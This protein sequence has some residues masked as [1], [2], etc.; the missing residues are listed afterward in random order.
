MTIPED[1]ERVALLGWAVF[2]ASQY[3][4]ASCF[5]GAHDAATSDL[6]TIS[7]WCRDYPSCNWRLAFGLSQLWGL[8]IDAISED[9][10]ADGIGAMRNLTAI[11]GALPPCPMTKSGGGGFAVFFKHN[12]EPITGKTGMPS[13]GID[14]RRG[15]LSVTIP[16][17]IHLTTKLAYRWIAPP[18]SVNAPNAPGWLLRAV[19]PPP[20]PVHRAAPDLSSGDKAR[21][22]AVGALKSAIAK[23]A[24]APSG[25]ANSTLNAETYAIGRFLSDGSVTEGEVRDCMVAAARAR[26][27]PIREAMATID[28][29]LRARAR[30]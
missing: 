4:R 24:C 1:I 10:A 12:G 13:P 30:A 28:S 8:D 17:S 21:S 6:D 3:S 23:V 5:S 22:Y 29:G 18:W 11:N 7:G 25:A 9:H 20:E 2:P 16:P 27:I 14:P 15:R 26:G 19:A